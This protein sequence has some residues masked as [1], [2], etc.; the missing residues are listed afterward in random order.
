MATTVEKAPGP[1]RCVFC[2]KR[3]VTR[4]HVWPDWILSLLCDNLTYTNVVVT[5]EGTTYTGTRPELKV[6]RVC[7]DCNHKWM[8]Q[9]E[10]AVQPVLEPMIMGRAPVTLA[11]ASKFAL[12]QWAMKTALV[13]DLCHSAGKRVFPSGLYPSFF[14]RRI[15]P[16]ECA[17]WAMAYRGEGVELRGFATPLTSALPAAYTRDGIV[18][19]GGAR[20]KG[21][22]VTIQLNRAVLQ[23]AMFGS[24]AV[25]VIMANEPPGSIRIWPKQ[26]STTDWPIRNEAFNATEFDELIRRRIEV[27][28]LV[29]AKLL[30]VKPRN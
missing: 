8:S 29:P 11:P 15:P 19:A 25:P 28:A 13:L 20:V 21:A 3:P 9:M 10:S 27:R 6:K 2:G 5:R 12:A 14:Q 4:E 1:R 26:T 22:L 18:E 30:A 17:V 23:M 16:K 7:G 24:G